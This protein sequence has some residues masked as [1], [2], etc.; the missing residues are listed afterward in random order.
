MQYIQ[1]QPVIKCTAYLVVF[2]LSHA[3]SIIKLGNYIYKQLKK[4]AHSL[5]VFRR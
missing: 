1:H 2:T 5:S 4:E 3:M